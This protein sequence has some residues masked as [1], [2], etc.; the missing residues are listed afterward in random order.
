MKRMCAVC[1]DKTQINVRKLWQRH[2]DKK[3]FNTCMAC[4]EAGKVN[5]DSVKEITD[6]AYTTLGED[7]NIVPYK[8]NRPK[9]TGTITH[10]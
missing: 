5:A 9:R 6:E 4:A 7:A 10:K 8:D 1:G 2:S 3:V